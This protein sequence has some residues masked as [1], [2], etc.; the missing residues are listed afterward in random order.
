MTRIDEKFI[1]KRRGMRGEN[2]GK[3][4]YSPRVGMILNIDRASKFIFEYFMNKRE[5]LDNKR[6]LTCY[7]MLIARLLLGR[8]RYIYPFKIIVTAQNNG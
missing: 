2:K 3:K 1:V 4:F 7:F 6:S 5:V 8:H